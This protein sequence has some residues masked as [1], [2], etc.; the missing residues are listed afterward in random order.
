MIRPVKMVA[1]AFFHI[2]V[3]SQRGRRPRLRPGSAVVVISFIVVLLRDP[4]FGGD[5][6]RLS[7]GAEGSLKE[8]SAAQR[9]ILID[10]RGTG[11]SDRVAGGGNAGEAKR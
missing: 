7:P 4:S 6:Y 5:V 2:L 3:G 8:R 11:M 10:K 9:M 1:A